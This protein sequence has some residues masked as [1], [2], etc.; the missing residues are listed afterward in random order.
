MKA[1]REW[2]LFFTEVELLGLRDPDVETPSLAS[3]LFGG[4][5]IGDSLLDPLIALL[6]LGVRLGRRARIREEERRDVLHEEL[7]LLRRES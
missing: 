3:P 5:Q 4:V 2:F 7:P 6:A 1:C